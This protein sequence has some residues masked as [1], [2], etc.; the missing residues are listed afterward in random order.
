M[1]FINSYPFHLL[2]A[3]TIESMLGEKAIIEALSIWI[4]HA[5][6]LPYQVL[7]DNYLKNI[8]GSEKTSSSKLRAKFESD[9]LL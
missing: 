9:H 5:S 8:K 3:L 7:S 2:Q 6:A 1:H 4:H